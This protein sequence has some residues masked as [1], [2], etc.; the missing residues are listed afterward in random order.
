ML[1]IVCAAVEGLK[2]IAK[3][4]LINVGLGILFAS[5]SLPLRGYSFVE[6]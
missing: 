1:L 3:S 5:A 2:P 4:N 6:K